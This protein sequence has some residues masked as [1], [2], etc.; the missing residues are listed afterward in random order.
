MRLLGK[1][2]QCSNWFVEELGATTPERVRRLVD[3]VPLWADHRRCDWCKSMDR[4]NDMHMF[5][6]EFTGLIEIGC[7]S[8]TGDEALDRIGAAPWLRKVRQGMQLRVCGQHE[9]D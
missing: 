5:F 2:V 9:E 3:E 6:E 7:D 1:C 8:A 4:R